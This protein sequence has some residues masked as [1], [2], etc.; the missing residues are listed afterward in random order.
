MPVR[1]IAGQPQK[2][3]KH[4]PILTSRQLDAVDLRYYSLASMAGRQVKRSAARLGV[5]SLRL[6][7]A[8]LA[9][10]SQ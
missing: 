7:V 5:F 1:F 3:K 8:R 2:R 4:L 10:D 9:R 6:S